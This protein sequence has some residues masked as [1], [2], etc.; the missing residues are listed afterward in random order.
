MRARAEDDKVLGD[1]RKEIGP[2]A[3]DEDARPM[4]GQFL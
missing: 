4:P 3:Q 2:S 1:L